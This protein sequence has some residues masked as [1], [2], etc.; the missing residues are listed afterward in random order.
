ML[1]KLHNKV[2]NAKYLCDVS[3]EQLTELGLPQLHKK[4]SQHDSN[5]NE[6]EK[7]S[8][9]QQQ[10]N[11]KKKKRKETNFIDIIKGMDNE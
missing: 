4:K 2:F 7:L 5:Q 6:D 9:K 10:L 8:S 3:H 11:L 1:E